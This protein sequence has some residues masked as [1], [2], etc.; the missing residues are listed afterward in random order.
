MT[1]AAAAAAD[2]QD[3]VTAEVIRIVADQAVLE[4]AEVK[5]SST[6]E[7]LGIVMV[8]SSWRGSWWMPSHGEPDAGTLPDSAQTSPELET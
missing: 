2:E 4:P 3:A 8:E 1:D 7:E 5:L 6:P